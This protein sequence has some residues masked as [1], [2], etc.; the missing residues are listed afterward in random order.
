M[1]F[2]PGPIGA[3]FSGSIGSTTASHNRFGPYLRTKAIPVNPNTPRQQTVRAAFTTLVNAWNNNLNA[4]QRDAWDNWADQT[5]I[6]G[7]DGQPINIT[8]QNAYIRF[9]T[10]VLQTL[11]VRQDTAPLTFN[12]GAPVT[13]FQTTPS[14]FIGIIGIN[15]ALLATTA[16][17]S[18]GAPTSGKMIMYLGAPVNATRTFFKG[19]Y[20]LAATAA[21]APLVTSVDFTGNLVDMDQDIILA[22]GQFR[23]IRFRIAYD[24]GRLSEP[25]QA[26]ADVFDDT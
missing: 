25:F 17:I 22:D 21:V 1:K 3:D 11:G 19:P 24:D 10:P 9:N 16:S 13:S 2:T 4:A 12:N 8:G 23:S 20:Q 5:P 7:K 15:G 26:L 14:S 6:L 18:S